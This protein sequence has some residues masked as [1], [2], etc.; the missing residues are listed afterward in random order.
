M[1][2]ILSSAEYPAIRAAL[3][4][5]ISSNDLPDTVIGQTI[6]LAAAE[7]ELVD[8]VPTAAAMTGENLAR[9]KR[10]LI[11]LTAAYLAG[12]VVRITSMT[13]QTRDLSYSKAIFDPE[14]KAAELRARAEVEISLLTTPEA[15]N[16]GM[17]TMFTRA[18]GTRGA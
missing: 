18:T 12:S 17:P 3:D 2:A 7:S 6:F 4:V 1:P 5:S 10:I 15:S 16:P 11:W 8:R 14:K 9:V 13:V